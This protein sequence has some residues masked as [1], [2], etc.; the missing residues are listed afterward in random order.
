[1]HGKS[2]HR[3][4][5]MYAVTM[6]A[7]CDSLGHYIFFLFPCTCTGM[8]PLRNCSLKCCMVEEWRPYINQIKK[9]SPIPFV[10]KKAKEVIPC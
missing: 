10:Q 1:M 2:F 6:R 5:S 4:V 9:G 8:H 3:Q 7:I